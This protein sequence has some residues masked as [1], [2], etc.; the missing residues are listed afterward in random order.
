MDKKRNYKKKDEKTIFV[1]ELGQKLLAD[2]ELEEVVL[3]TIL[4]ESNCIDN[5]GGMFNENL[6]YFDEH[7]LIAR[8]ILDLFLK[9][10]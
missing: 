10:S 8:A 1:E 7:K 3:G 9:N 4:L 6:F 2:K 5:V